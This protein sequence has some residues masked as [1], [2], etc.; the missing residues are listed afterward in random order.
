M[1][2]G[3]A[4]VNAESGTDRGKGRFIF[5]FTIPLDDG[6]SKSKFIDHTTTSL[7]AVLSVD[8][9]RAKSVKYKDIYK[10]KDGNCDITFYLL[11]I[12]I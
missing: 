3:T 8:V 4:G 2:K 9:S 1:L 5:C 12:R 7:L 6:K 11:Y 10:Q